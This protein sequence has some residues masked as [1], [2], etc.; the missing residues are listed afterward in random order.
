VVFLI[1]SFHFVNK[2]LVLFIFRIILLTHCA[3]T[4]LLYFRSQFHFSIYI[5]IYIYIYIDTNT[6]THTHTHIYTHIHIYTYI[7]IY[8]LLLSRAI[9]YI[10]ERPILFATHS[11]DRLYSQSTDS[12]SLQLLSSSINFILDRSTS[13]P[14]SLDRL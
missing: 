12:I 1:L 9:D 10:V 2:N 7:L 3:H 13:T 14:K 8:L 6:H 5:Y 11:L 4:H